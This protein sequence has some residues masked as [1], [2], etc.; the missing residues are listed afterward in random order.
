MST[1]TRP[2][3]QAVPSAGAP[4]VTRQ[5]AAMNVTP[6]R[7]AAVIIALLGEGAARPIVEKLDDAAL[8]KVVREL[9]TIHVL[10]RDVLI[11]IVIDFLGHLNNNTGALRGGRERCAAWGVGCA[12]CHCVAVL[13]ALRGASGALRGAWAV[14]LHSARA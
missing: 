2:R 14:R 4:A 6:A 10:P 8:A 12:L 1:Q 13:G 9:E 7:R 3:P 11:E 5:P